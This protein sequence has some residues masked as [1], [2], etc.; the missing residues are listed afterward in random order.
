MKYGA[1]CVAAARGLQPYE[2]RRLLCSGSLKAAATQKAPKGFP[3][4][5]KQSAV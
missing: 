5:G 3:S 4:L 1:F 2:V